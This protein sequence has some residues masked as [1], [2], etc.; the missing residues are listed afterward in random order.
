MTEASNAWKAA[1]SP[2]PLEGLPVCIQM[3]EVGYQDA[4]HFSRVDFCLTLEVRSVG[5]RGTVAEP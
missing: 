2:V 5:D 3:G 4:L 1:P